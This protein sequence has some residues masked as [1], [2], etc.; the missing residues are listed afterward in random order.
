MNDTR[1]IRWWPALLVLVGAVGTLIWVWFFT[2]GIRQSKILATLSIATLAA[3]L[4][5][6]WF[7]LLSRAAAK[8]RLLALVAVALTVFA[9]T[10]LYE[11]RGVTGDLRPILSRKGGRTEIAESS[12]T[13]GDGT[14]L[15]ASSVRDFPQFLGPNR[16]GTIQGVG[17]ARDWDARAPRELWRTEIG[18]G[19]ASFAVWGDFAVT[20][21]QRGDEEWVT[22]YELGTGQMRW[23]HSDE[24]RF[25]KT[26]G[27]V[28]PRATP[29]VDGSA[30]YTMGATGI[31]NALDLQSGASLWSHDLVKEY[32]VGLPEWGRSSS[33]LLVEDLVVVV[34]GTP[35]DEVGAAGP[36]VGPGTS[37]VAFR[38]DTG[39]EVWASGTDGAGY[40]SPFLV[41]LG[42]V[43]QIIVFH[44]ASVAGYEPTDGQLLWQHPWP[45]QQPNV[46]QPLPLAGDRLLVSSGYG[47]GAKMLEIAERAD[48]GLVAS[49]IWESPRLKAKFAHYVEFEGSI[50][51]LDD[52][53][54]VCLDPETGERRWKRGRY[55]HG[56]LLLVDDLIVLQ[57]EGGDV[58]LIEPNPEELRELG[59]FTAFDRKTWN[60]PTLAGPYLLVRNDHEAALFELPL[61]AG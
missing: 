58:V 32:G 15:V 26:I 16:N 10:S 61:E 3:L 36:R 53:I 39:E 1:R 29:T 4:L 18:D 11:I 17:L 52:G 24:V 28:G 25:D 22:A 38:R 50:Y 23:S 19:W 9:V 51:G 21:E 41:T 20:Q 37:V 60:V 59:R 56:Q 49:M 35:P 55:G 8:W 43:P 27:G 42:G 47:V 33:P 54:F 7:L 13:T 6:L 45:Y 40:A 14:R 30:V 2:D 12:V 31:V 5:V 48:G 57:A 46:A 34:V 44:R